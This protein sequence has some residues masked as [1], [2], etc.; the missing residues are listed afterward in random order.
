MAI[1]GLILSNKV[2]LW[3]KVCYLFNCR[4]L[5]PWNFFKPL[6]LSLISQ[7]DTTLA[8]YWVFLFQTAPFS[9]SKTPIFLFTKIDH[10]NNWKQIMKTGSE[11]FMFWV[12]H[13]SICSASVCPQHGA[14]R[15][16]GSLEEDSIPLTEWTKI[17][18]ATCWHLLKELSMLSTTV[19]SIPYT[20]K[21]W[22]TSEVSGFH[23]II[24]PLA[25]LK[26]RYHLL[27]SLPS[28]ALLVMAVG[29]LWDFHE[30]AIKMSQILWE[31]NIKHLSRFKERLYCSFVRGSHLSL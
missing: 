2:V 16:D 4:L 7:E 26:C 10:L 3:H 27:I 19:L 12:S 1:Q 21:T 18:L 6:C 9:V 22:S 24:V 11:S 8:L 30:G 20:C 13:V 5:F 31:R 17:L 15:E 29:D 28:A 23:C 14:G 25:E